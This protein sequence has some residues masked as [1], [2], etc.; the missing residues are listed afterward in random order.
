[1]KIF[2]FS[3]RF[4]SHLEE[5]SN[6]VWE[7]IV[8]ENKYSILCLVPSQDS[9]SDKFQSHGVYFYWCMRLQKIWIRQHH[10]NGSDP[11]GNETSSG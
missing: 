10:K 5:I 2:V 6:Q 8:L 7:K 3:V 1:M 9:F 11:K 4:S